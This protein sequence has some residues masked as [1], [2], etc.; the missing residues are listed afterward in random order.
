ML[1]VFDCGTHTKNCFSQRS[2][3]TAYIYPTYIYPIE[4]LIFENETKIY[5]KGI[6]TLEGIAAPE[7]IIRKLAVINSTYDNALF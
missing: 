3:H 7:G 6:I 1:W 5:L 4:W 2:F